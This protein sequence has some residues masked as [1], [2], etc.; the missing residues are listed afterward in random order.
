VAR[1]R[2]EAAVDETVG[3]FPALGPVLDRPA[4][5]LSGGEQQMLAL[6]RALVT[7]PRVLLVDEM[8]LGLAPLV[9]EA[10]LPVVRAAATEHGAA[11]VV[12]EQ[13]VTAALAVADRAVV[14]RG[15]RVALVAEAADLRADRGVLEA[16]YL[17]DG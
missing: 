16:S 2:A 10:L 4:G 1:R 8:S 11:V 17:G 7:R 14:L 13:H 9:V 12:V 15:G 3:W 6:A 5:L